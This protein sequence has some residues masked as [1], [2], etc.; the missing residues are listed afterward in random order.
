M[1]EK[2]IRK[3]KKDELIQKLFNEMGSNE[4]RIR[5]IYKKY[6]F[7]F[8]LSPYDVENILGITKTERL[9]W[10][11][12]EKLKVAGYNSFR[13]YG[14]TIEYPKYDSFQ[15]Y[16]ISKK[17]L[18]KWREE[19]KNEVNKKRKQAINKAK[20]TRKRNVNIQKQFYEKEWKKILVEWY[21]VDSKLGVTMELAYWTMWVS[22][23]AKES[24][25]KSL[26]ARTKKKEYDENKANFYQMKNEAIK[27]LIQSSF[28][29][30]SFYKPRNADKTTYIQFCDVHFS[31]WGIEREFEYVSK[32]DFYAWHKKEIQKCDS[33]MVKVVKDYYSLFYVSIQHEELKDYHFSFH[34]PYPIGQVFLPDKANLPNV[35]HEEQEGL[36]RFGRPLVGDE[37]VI[38]TIKNTV[39]HFQAALTKFDLYF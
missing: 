39:K 9:R 10:T 34:I 6:S 16:H 2:E 20:T 19:H 17:Q 7:E 3:R 12:D 14:K 36:F 22:R 37:K 1:D 31:L 27:R 38:F 33:C 18:E 35:V 21:K 24:Q 28:S 13:K 26:S 11:K 5:D 32:W 30:L 29:T 4:V 23:W 15:I 8:S 25:L